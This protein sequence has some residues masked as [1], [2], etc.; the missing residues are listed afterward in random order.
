MSRYRD[1]NT[2][3]QVRS[4]NLAKDH[5][6][7]IRTLS[8]VSEDIPTFFRMERA[9]SM[10]S[11]GMFGVAIISRAMDTMRL[12]WFCALWQYMMEILAYPMSYRSL[13]VRTASWKSGMALSIRLPIWWISP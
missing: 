3:W 13:A 7:I 10:Y 8:V 5:C 6:R 2:V 4:K 12:G 9:E 11:A 1:S